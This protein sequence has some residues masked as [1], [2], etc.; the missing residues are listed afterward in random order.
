MSGDDE[1]RRSERERLEAAAREASEKADVDSAGVYF[2]SIEEFEGRAAP[3]EAERPAGPSEDERPAAPSEDERPA[4]PS[5]AEDGRDP[6]A[7]GV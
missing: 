2:M 3:S 4:A 6:S 7:E 1:R 5:E